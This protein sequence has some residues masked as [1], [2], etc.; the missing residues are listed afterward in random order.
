MTWD[1][2]VDTC[3]PPHGPLFAWMKVFYQA[4]GRAEAWAGV[5]AAAVSN[6]SMALG[7]NA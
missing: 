6:Q 5:E 2:L 4:H 3:P 7:C 1:A